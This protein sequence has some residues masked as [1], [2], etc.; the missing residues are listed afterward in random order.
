MT[1][2]VAAHGIVQG[3]AIARAESAPLIAQVR[4]FRLLIYIYFV[5]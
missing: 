3:P 5:H 4:G 1:G 2:V